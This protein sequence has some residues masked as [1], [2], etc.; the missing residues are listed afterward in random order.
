M[1]A[2]APAPAKYKDPEDEKRKTDHDGGGLHCGVHPFYKGEE[3]PKYK[4]M[5]V[6]CQEIWNIKKNE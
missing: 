6:R 1:S 3:K 2:A 4:F 5:C